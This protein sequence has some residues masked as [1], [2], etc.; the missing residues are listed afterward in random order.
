MATLRAKCPGC[1]SWVTLT[2]DAMEGDLVVCPG[3]R[4]Q[5]EIINIEPPE[6]DYADWEEE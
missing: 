5:L 6:L 4:E 3:C 2:E 1:E